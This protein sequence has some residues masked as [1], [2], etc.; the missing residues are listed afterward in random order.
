MIETTDA[1]K[2]NVDKNLN[3]SVSLARKL[4][5]EGSIF[6]YPTDTI[7]GIG[8]NP[9]NENAVKKINKIK[10]RKSDKKN[11]LLINN[12][13]NLLE[14]V[15]VQ[16]EKHIDFFLAIWPNPVSVILNLNNKYKKILNNSNAAFRIP[17]NRFCLKLLD[18]IKMPLISTSVNKS[19]KSPINEPSLIFE[20]FSN[21]IDN[22]FYSTKKNF[23]KASTLVDLTGKK[24][25]ILRQGKIKIDRIV[26]KY[27]K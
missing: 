7:Y 14:Y 12:I 21:I 20:E 18:E 5:F 27:L 17:N 9:F 26:D 11:I 16:S 4:F 22:I 1:L 25:K 19:N 15:D 3:D 6:I 23:N 24:P 10:G 2:I 8:A 13:D